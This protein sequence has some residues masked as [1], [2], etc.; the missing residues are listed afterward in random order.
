MTKGNKKL[1]FNLIAFHNRYTVTT[2]HTVYNT[3]CL[4]HHICASE[5][6]HV[7]LLY[8][9]EE[10]T[11]GP[12]KLIYYLFA[13]FIIGHMCNKQLYDCS[14][15]YGFSSLKYNTESR[16]TQRFLTHPVT[17]HW[18]LFNPV[19]FPAFAPLPYTNTADIYRNKKYFLQAQLTKIG[20]KQWT[21]KKKKN[22]IMR[23]WMCSHVQFYSHRLCLCLSSE[24]MA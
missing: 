21:T 13:G 22:D 15:K 14:C 3:I 24:I 23:Y 18:M 5:R 7:F 2:Q 16:W 12:L 10:N 1:F 8:K 20:E 17:M 9:Y 6:L 11:V 4:Q 19:Y